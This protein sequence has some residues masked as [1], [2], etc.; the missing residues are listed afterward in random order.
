M[1]EAN[2]QLELPLPT[3]EESGAAP[4]THTRFKPT[5]GEYYKGTIR[6]LQVLEEFDRIQVAVMF[7]AAFGSVSRVFAELLA[8]GYIE[9]VVDEVNGEKVPRKREYSRNLLNRNPDLKGFELN[10][11]HTKHG[12]AETKVYRKARSWPEL[13]T[14]WRAF[15]IERERRRED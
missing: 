15:L 4:R 3:R 13:I 1:P 9:E 7:K 8:E 6:A 14:R 10:Y 12:I 11:A 2:I 5:E